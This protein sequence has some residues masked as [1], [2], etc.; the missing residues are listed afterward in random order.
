MAVSYVAPDILCLVAYRSCAPSP[1]AWPPMEIE[2]M[3]TRENGIGDH[4]HSQSP[5]VTSTMSRPRHCYCH[6][7]PSCLTTTALRDYERSRLRLLAAPIL[8]QRP[9]CRDCP[10]LRPPDRRKCKLLPLV[11]TPTCIPY[12]HIL[13]S[14]TTC[15]RCARG[16]ERLQCT[17][18]I[19]PEAA[20]ASRY[21]A[22]LG[23]PGCHVHEAKYPVSFF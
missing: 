9:P 3:T 18:K 5:P 14:I 20:F 8:S 17:S 11:T 6:C 19:Y 4:G 12:T 1:D 2:L 13:A 22:A 15:E 10:H 23:I 16:F 21:V 7:Q